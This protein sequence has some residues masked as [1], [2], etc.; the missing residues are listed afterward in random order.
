VNNP[1]SIAQKVEKLI[2][3]R[4]SRDYIVERARRM[5]EDKY[6]WSRVAGE[7]RNLFLG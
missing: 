6:Q 3:D 7:M 4:E 1:R 2:K 5:V